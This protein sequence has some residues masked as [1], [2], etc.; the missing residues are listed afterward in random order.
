MRSAHSGTVALGGSQTKFSSVQ[1]GLSSAKT[2]PKPKSH[3]CKLRSRGS[4][5]IRPGTQAH[6]FP[7]PF[8]RI[9]AERT[10]LIAKKSSPRLSRPSASYRQVA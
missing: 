6:E 10:G 9:L 4:H 3:S 1:R 2:T 8:L 7:R 5:E